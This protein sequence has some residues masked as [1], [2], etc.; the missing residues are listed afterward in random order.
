MGLCPFYRSAGRRRKLGESQLY[1]CGEAFYRTYSLC[2]KMHYTVNV[3]EKGLLRN[4]QQHRNGTVDK[5]DP[6]NRNTETRFFCVRISIFGTKR[7]LDFYKNFWQLQLLKKAVFSFVPVVITMRKA[8]SNILS[9][10]IALKL[11][12]LLRK[13]W[14]MLLKLYFVG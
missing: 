12:Q 10:P 14:R 13:I 4:I 8:L 11:E 1:Q 9:S 5:V 7:L 3:A 6:S 2:R